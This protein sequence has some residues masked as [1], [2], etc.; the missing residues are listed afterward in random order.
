M[1]TDELPLTINVIRVIFDE[2]L[3]QIMDL[4]GLIIDPRN[5]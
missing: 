2:K 4:P 1:D 5:R 3:L